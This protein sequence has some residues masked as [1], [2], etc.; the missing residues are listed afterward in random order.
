MPQEPSYQSL[1]G[2]DSSW[3][4]Q[5]QRLQEYLSMPRFTQRTPFETRRCLGCQTSTGDVYAVFSTEDG[6]REHVHLN[7]EPLRTEF[8]SIPRISLQTPE[9]RQTYSFLTLSLSQEVSIL[10]SLGWE[11]GYRYEIRAIMDVM[12]QDSND[13]RYLTV[14]IWNRTKGM[15]LS[16]IIGPSLLSQLIGQTADPSSSDT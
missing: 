10:Q 11:P 7:L 2:A 13:D 12:D 16:D 6:Q 3:I 8:L 5:F 14:V 4:E 1:T 15:L 9:Q